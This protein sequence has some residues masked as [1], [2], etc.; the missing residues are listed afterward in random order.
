MNHVFDI[1]MVPLQVIILLFT[2]Y[3]FFIGFCGMW[4]R[5][6]NKILT[7][8]KTF[9]VIIAAH[10]ESAVI[11]Q[12]LQNLQSLDYPKTLYDVFVIA[13][14]CDDNTAEIARG[15]GSIVCE[16]THPT[17]KSKGFAMEWMFERLFKM[18]KK[19]DAV[20]Y[21]QNHKEFERLDIKS[22]LKED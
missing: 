1:V 20:I 15:Y 5:K 7:P 8:K 9:A 12:L 17:K 19:Y 4:R 10:N 21:A 22:L 18:E 16:R 14:N 13:D 6:E 3:Y 11:G 2:L